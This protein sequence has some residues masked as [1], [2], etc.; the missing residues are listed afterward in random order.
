MDTRTFEADLRRD[1]YQDIE[2]KSQPADVHVGSHAHDFDVRALVLSGEVTLSWDGKTQTYRSGEVFTMAAG[3]PH[4][5]QYGPQ[6]YTYL[7]G[8]RRPDS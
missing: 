7:V 2:T 8:R 1:G 4:T 6:G 3:C 5:E